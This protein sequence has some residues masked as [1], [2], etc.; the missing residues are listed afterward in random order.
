VRSV[1]PATGGG[2]RRQYCFADFT[3]DLDAGF[4]RRG[5]EEVTLSPKAFE[6]LAYLVQHHG[7]LV[8]KT[9]LIEEVWPDTVVTDNSLAQRLL[10]IRRALADESQQ[11]IR[12]VARRGYVFAAPVTSP[13]VEFPRQP[14]EGPAETGPSAVPSAPASQRA[15]NRK[16]LAGALI[17]LAVIAGGLL[18]IRLSPPARRELTYT[19]IT[20]FTDSAVAPALSPDGPNGRVLPER[21]LVSLSRSDLR[22][23]APQWRAG[24]TYQ[25]SQA[26]IRLGVLAGRLAHRVYRGRWLENIH[27]VSARR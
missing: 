4:L 19:Q 27:G 6:I 21:H 3:L 14:A 8:T 11:L 5:G 26:Q 7:R 17:V 23:T 18:L 16:I 24:S 1:E 2:S 9:A 13:V 12:T 20:N 25:R 22:E 15:L 10:E